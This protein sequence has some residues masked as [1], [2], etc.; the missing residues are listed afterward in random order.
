ME[1]LRDYI[2]LICIVLSSTLV[3]GTYMSR[4][5]LHMYAEGPHIEPSRLDQLTTPAHTLVSM[6]YK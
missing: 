5:K 3:D 2:K 4:I 6:M 1:E